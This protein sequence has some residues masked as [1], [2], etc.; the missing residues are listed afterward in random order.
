LSYPQ[1]Q[2]ETATVVLVHGLWHDEWAWDQV[3][4][5]LTSRGVPSEAVHLPLT[6]LKVDVAAATALVDSIDGSIVLVG[7][8]YGGAVI[9]G[10]GEHPKVRRLVYFAGFAL[11]ETESIGRTL[12]ELDIPATA[13]GDAL[14]FSADGSQVAIDPDDARALLYPDVPTELAD[15][16]IGRLRPVGR[17]LFSARPPAVAWRSRPSTYVISEQDLVVHPDLQRAMAQRTSDRLTWECGHSALASRPDEVAEL[18]A[19]L[20]R[21]AAAPG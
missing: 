3:R 15:A 12:P 19:G 1:G 17:A 13:L 18:L 2:A 11:S 7:H 20:A 16:A 9:T 5:G 6:E 21:S 8:S 4:L 14:R 10:A